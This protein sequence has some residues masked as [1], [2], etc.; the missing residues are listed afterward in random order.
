M[1]VIIFDF[2]GTIADSFDVVLGITNRLANEFGFPPA[3]PEDVKLL[4]NMTSREI[5]RQS[6]VSLL[7]Y[8]FYYD[9]CE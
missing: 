5:L 8:R 6:G 7:S 4:K 2:D 9:G 1:K 3:R